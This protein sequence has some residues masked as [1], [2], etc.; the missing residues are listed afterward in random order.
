MDANAG[1]R[2]AGRWLVLAALL[3]AGFTAAAHDTIVPHHLEDVKDLAH[4]RDVRGLALVIT[5]AFT[6]VLATVIFLAMRYAPEDEDPADLREEQERLRHALLAAA[7]AVVEGESEELLEVV[8][9]ML[10]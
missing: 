9:P 1:M 2:R 6:V 7:E 10:C 4:A 5:I 3:L 8:N